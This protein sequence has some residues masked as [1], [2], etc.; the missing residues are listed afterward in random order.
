MQKSTPQPL[1]VAF[2]LVTLV[3]MVIA[4]LKIGQRVYLT[5]REAAKL[6]GISAP[7]LVRAI[8]RGELEV[9][10]RIGKIKLVDAEAAEK[11][12]EAHYHAY[13]AKAAKTRWGT[14]Q[15]RR[16]KRR[17]LKRREKR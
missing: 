8:R 9:F 16:Q 7:T 6:L 13:R 17:E 5:L 3:A 10:A 1:R 12:K 11:W 4:M 2:R 14:L 15:R